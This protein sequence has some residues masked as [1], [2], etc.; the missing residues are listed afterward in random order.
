MNLPH[1]MKVTR[2]HHLKRMTVSQQYQLLANQAV[3]DYLSVQL[4]LMRLMPP[5]AL[6]HLQSYFQ[7]KQGH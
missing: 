3:Q 4:L 2:K 5:F 6:G 7:A 1:S